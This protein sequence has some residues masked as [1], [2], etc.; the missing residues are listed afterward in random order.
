M[1]R[2]KVP[3][4]LFKKTWVDFLKEE[5]SNDPELTMQIFFAICDYGYGGV[6]P[7][8]L[9]L[10]MA[11][12]TIRKEID[13]DRAAYEELSDKRRQVRLEAVAN[14]QKQQNEQMLTNATNG[15]NGTTGTN[16]EYNNI[17]NNN[18]SSSNDSELK[19][20]NK[21]TKAK[22]VER[23]L[24]LEETIFVDETKERYPRIMAMKTPLTLNDYN[25]LVSKYGEELVNDK[26]NSLENHADI[27]KYV[28]AKMTLENWCK[29]EIKRNGTSR[30]GNQG[31]KPDLRSSII[32]NLINGN[33]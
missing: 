33:K 17:L 7:D 26:M 2:V 9:T 8:D 11:T 16:I 5:F 21:K 1:A 20:N 13:D 31:A 10:R 14:K 22:K 3:H 6:I 24:S 19:L 25:Y 12:G 27:K 15:T 30:T 23:E 32:G 28:S 18:N 4:I 29:L